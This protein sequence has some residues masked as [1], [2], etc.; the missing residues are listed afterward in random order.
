MDVEHEVLHVPAPPGEDEPRLANEAPAGYVC[1]TAREKDQRAVPWLA[2]QVA[3][4]GQSAQPLTSNTPVLSA[5][6]HAILYRDIMCKPTNPEQA[7][8][9]LSRLF[10]PAPTGPHPT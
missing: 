3:S 1:R 5:A 6:T 9:L 7:G 2:K 4:A 10:P 8:R